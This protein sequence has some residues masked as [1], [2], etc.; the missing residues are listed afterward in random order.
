MAKPTARETTHATSPAPYP[1]I[2]PSSTSA[3]CAAKGAMAVAKAATAAALLS[4]VSLMGSGSLLAARGFTAD[5]RVATG[6]KAEA[7]ATIR[8]IR[9][10]LKVFIL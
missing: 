3:A 1:I 10:T 8:A 9:R 7:Q 4:L 5:E 6:V 2:V